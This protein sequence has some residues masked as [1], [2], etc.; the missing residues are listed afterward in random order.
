MNYSVVRM[1]VSFDTF[2]ERSKIRSYVIPVKTGIQ[3]NNFYKPWIP[4]LRHR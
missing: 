4:A 2:A 3:D 1:R